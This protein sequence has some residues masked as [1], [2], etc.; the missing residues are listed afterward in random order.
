MADAYKLYKTCE[1][2]RGVGSLIIP[3]GEY[4]GQNTQVTCPVC[5]GAKLVLSGY[6]TVATY[7]IPEVPE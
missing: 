6:C 1:H 4:P 7:P 2:C 5:N 3:I